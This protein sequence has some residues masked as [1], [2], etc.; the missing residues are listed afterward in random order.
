MDVEAQNWTRT[1]EVAKRIRKDLAEGIMDPRNHKPAM[2]QKKRD[3]YLAFPK[4]RF[5]SNMLNI[6][7]RSLE[8][9]R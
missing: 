5:S 6:V 8:A 2:V 4:S 1:C 7:I 3:V 9:K